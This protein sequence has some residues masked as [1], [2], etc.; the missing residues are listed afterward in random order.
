MSYL[1]HH[2]IIG[3][4]WGVRRFQNEDGSYTELGKRRR[5]T[6]TNISPDAQRYAEL[7]TKRPEEMSNAELR[8][9]N[10]RAALENTYYKNV[11]PNTIA[12]GLAIVAGATAGILILNNAYTGTRDLVRNG[13]EVITLGKGA[14]DAFTTLTTLH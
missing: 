14:L 13:K 12:K 7:K 6:K 11:N 4:K 3:Q 9:Y 8:E 2:G 1:M 10:H 5:G